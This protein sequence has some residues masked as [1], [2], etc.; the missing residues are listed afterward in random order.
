[1]GEDYY[2][3]PWPNLKYD[4]RLGG[5]RVGVTEDQLKGAPKY[6]RSTDWNWSDR[7]NDRA[8]VRLLQYTSLVLMTPVAPEIPAPR[9]GFFCGEQD[10]N[11]W[12]CAKRRTFRTRRKGFQG[13]GLEER[14][15]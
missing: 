7:A 3:M 5:Y 2:P 14:R 10:A 12:A 9:G 6:S 15:S 13:S 8:G 11:S 4:T 1:M